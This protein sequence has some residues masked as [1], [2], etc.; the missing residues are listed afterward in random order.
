[1][2]VIKLLGVAVLVLAVSEAAWAITLPTYSLGTVQVKSRNQDNGSAYFINDPEAFATGGVGGTSLFGVALD[3][4]NLPAS[5]TQLKPL[6]AVPQENS[7]ELEDT[8]GI[9]HLYFIKQGELVGANTQVAGT[10]GALAWDNSNGGEDTWIVGIFYGGN[11]TS[12][13]F[14]N[15]NNATALN[16]DTVGV[17]FELWAVDKAALSA[18]AVANNVGPIDPENLVDFDALNRTADNRYAGWVD[19]VGI[20]LVSGE[21]TEFTFDG[22]ISNNG[23]SFDGQTTAYFDID[24]NDPTGLWNAAWGSTPQ[25]VSLVNNVLSD[26]Y[27]TWDLGVSNRDWNVASTDLGGVSAV[28]P[29]PLTMIGLVLAVGSVGGYIRRRRIG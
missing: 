15:T 11:D 7:Q 26:A 25:L 14:N 2:R 8:W 18:S 20:K 23:L 24:E 4:D 10:P 17:K 16:I 21:S 19:G 29:E 27:F 28:I 1:M 3:P 12:V 5:V 6:G 13:T 9:L 22:T